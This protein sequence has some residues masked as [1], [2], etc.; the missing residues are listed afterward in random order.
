MNTQSMYK[1]A[2]A[3]LKNDEDV[4]DAIQTV[5]GITPGIKW[6]NDIV[7]DG[8][9]VCGILTEMSTEMTWIHYVVIGV[10]INVHQQTFQRN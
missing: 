1:V 3:Y 5:T 8:R 9:K 7:M 2:W 6:P 10:G 4:A